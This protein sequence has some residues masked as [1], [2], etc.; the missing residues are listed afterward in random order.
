MTANLLRPMTTPEI[1]GEGFRLYRDHLASL[2]SIALLPHLALL[3]LGTLLDALG[4]SPVDALAILLLATLVLNAIVLAAMTHALAHAALGRMPGVGE[5]YR[6]GFGGRV[7]WIV[8]AYLVVWVAV[9]LGLLAFVLPGLII[10]A[11]LLPTVPLIVLED[12]RPFPALARAVAMMR[13]I[14]LRGMAIFAFVILI[15]GVL[16]LALQVAAGAGP[17]APLLGAILGAVTLP[18]AYAVNVV[19]YFSVRGAEGYTADQLE[20]H[21]G[22]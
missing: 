13:P 21:L 5:S 19:L 6:R 2:I 18:L 20:A 16:P 1:I 17:F 4:L 11:L 15:S 9:S 8:A 14:V 22:S 10:G 7:L 12:L 3:A